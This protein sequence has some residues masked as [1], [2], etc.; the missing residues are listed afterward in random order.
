MSIAMLHSKGALNIVML[1]SK[2]TVNIVML[3]SKEDG[4][5]RDVM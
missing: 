5:Y 2:G 1:H 3:R 4:E